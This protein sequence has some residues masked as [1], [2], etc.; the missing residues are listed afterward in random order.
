MSRDPHSISLPVARATLQSVMSGIPSSRGPK[1]ASLK[2][3][4]FKNC[5]T[6]SYSSFVRFSCDEVPPASLCGGPGC[7]GFAELGGILL[8]CILR[9][10][11]GL[12]TPNIESAR[13]ILLKIPLDI[14]RP[15]SFDSVVRVIDSCG[16]DQH[17][18]HISASKFSGKL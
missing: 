14:S 17:P 3:C 9:T 12:E 4:R 11:S 7:A 5:R 13:P 15:L 2:N 16:A 1:V 18:P 8:A 10:S 6:A